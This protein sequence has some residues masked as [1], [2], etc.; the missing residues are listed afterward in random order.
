M[1]TSAMIAMFE[2]SR[3]EGKGLT[4]FLPGHQVSIVVTEIH[5]TEAVEGTNQEFE[6]MLVPT[7]QIVALAFQ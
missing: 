7:D 3:E 6:R 5:G 4:M 2:K 1:N